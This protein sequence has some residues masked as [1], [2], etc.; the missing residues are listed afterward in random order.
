MAQHIEIR[1]ERAPKI[2]QKIGASIEK[3]VAKG[4]CLTS[5]KWEHLFDDMWHTDRYIGKGIVWGATRG[6]FEVH[7]EGKVAK[8]IYLVA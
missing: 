3:E 1:N 7:V 8:H 2:L 6:Y 5:L 4:L